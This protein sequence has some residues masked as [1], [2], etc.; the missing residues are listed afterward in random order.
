MYKKRSFGI[1][2]M[3]LSPKGISITAQVRAAFFLQQA[4]L[5]TMR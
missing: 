2:D 4:I 1:Q 3:N 5:E